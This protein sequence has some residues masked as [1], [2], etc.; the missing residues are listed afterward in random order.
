MEEK[1]LYRKLGYIKISPYRTNT[2]KSIGEDMKM[3]SEIA[4]DINIRTSQV[5]AALSDL[6][7]QNLVICVNEEVRKGRLY[8]CTPEGLEILKYI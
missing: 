6:K 2:L 4:K 7:K 1:E 5:S 3:P 8:R